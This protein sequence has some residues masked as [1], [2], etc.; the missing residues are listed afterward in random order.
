VEE[1]VKRRL[2]L[3]VRVAACV[4]AG[5]VALLLAVDVA[6]TRAALEEDDVRYRTAPEQMLWAP[7]E[8]VPGEVAP[9]LLGV[10]DDLLFRRALR[11]VRLSHPEMPGFSDPAYVLHRNDASAWL[12]DVV[13]GDESRERR[14]AAAN[15]L[16][17]LSFAD[18]I[19]DYQNRAKL[20]EVAGSRFRQAISLDSSNEDAKVNLE[21]TLSRTRDF[22]LSEAGGGTDPSPGGRG[23]KGA[24]AGDAGS[25]Y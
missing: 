19:A 14:S 25:G 24:G 9:R 17:V 7:D 20:L 10:R 4:A 15:L 13:R 22:E 5:A 6:A 11:A 12:V 18:A 23:S 2:L 8:L 16:G 3:G 21:L 1:S